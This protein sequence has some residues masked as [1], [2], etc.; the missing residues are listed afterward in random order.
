MKR[1]DHSGLARAL[2]SRVQL[3]L[4]SILFLSPD[5][6]FHASELIRIA[7]SGSGAVQRELA[8]LSDAE[9]LEVS[10]SGNRKLYRVNKRSPIFS[11]LEQ[12]ILKTEGLV[13]PVKRALRPFQRAIAVAF[14]YGSVAKREDTARS[15]IDLM[16]IGSELSYGNIFGALQK[17]EKDLGRPINPNVMSPAEWRR[18][19]DEKRSFVSRIA[20][21]PKLFVYGS[22]DELQ[23][24]KQS[25]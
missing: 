16:M 5:K 10:R 6:D 15:D 22:E 11:E 3:R 13:E 20:Q 14:I 21:Q 8:R 2:F 18:K 24:I 17:V 4:L 7:K 23:R 1:S 25:G 12:I 9:I 19:L